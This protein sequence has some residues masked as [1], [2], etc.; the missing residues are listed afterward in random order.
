MVSSA[1]NDATDVSLTEVAA[2]LRGANDVLIQTHRNPDGDGIGAAL[3]L[4]TGVRAVGNRATVVCPDRL[5]PYLLQMPG[6][7]EV[8]HQLRQSTWDLVVAVDVSD[9]ALLQPLP[10]A[11][12]KF[13]AERHSLN[14]DHHFSNLRYARFNYV[15][16]SAASA[17][18]IISALLMDHLGVQLTA[19]IA[20][21]LLYGI[22]NDT[23]SFQNSNTSPQTLALSAQLVEAG[24]DLSRIVYNLL[25]ARSVESARLWAEVL[26]TLAFADDARVAF[27]T[28]SL[29]A[30]ERT[31]ATLTDADGLV[32][33]L[34]NIRGVDLAVLFK[35]TGPEEYR[36]SIRTSSAV[37]AT[38][39]AAAFGGG[40]HQRAAGGDARGDLSEIQ[41]R[42]LE[43]YWTSRL[44][45]SE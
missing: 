25:L 39:V 6:A 40:G 30:L 28:V 37:D 20:T 33:F 12:P 4:A 43:V 16:A 14:I 22:V 21:N 9:P 35:Q 29:E 19:D 15:D 31:G 27:L 7:H 2:L 32:E 38:V 5:P 3:A 18:E 23:H 34:R 41:G 8:R 36:L 1:A 17:T 10:S 24:A 26:P 45:P 42:L 44:A 11:D 13:F